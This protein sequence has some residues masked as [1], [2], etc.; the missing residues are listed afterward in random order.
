MRKNYY[1]PVTLILVL[2]GLF[3]NSFAQRSVT[4]EKGLSTADSEISRNLQENKAGVGDFKT[5]VPT[6][7][8]YSENWPDAERNFNPSELSYLGDIN[9]DGY[10]DMYYNAGKC[11]NDNTSDIMDFTY[12]SLIK[13]GSADQNFNDTIMYCSIY[14]IGDINGD[15]YDDVVKEFSDNTWQYALGSE[16]GLVESDEEISLPGLHQRRLSIQAEELFGPF[17]RELVGDTIGDFA[18]DL[19]CFYHLSQYVC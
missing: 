6:S 5:I 4:K 3:M 18:W 17:V 7:V 10:D 8:Y 1:K 13:Y 16:N 11:G 2:C 14:P 15:G 19:A 12:K 9:G